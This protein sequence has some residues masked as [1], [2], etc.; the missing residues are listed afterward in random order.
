MI[1]DSEFS[2]ATDFLSSG[3]VEMAGPMKHFKSISGL[4]ELIVNVENIR[5]MEEVLTCDGK[6]VWL[7]REKHLASLI[8][9]ETIKLNLA[10]L[11]QSEVPFS[12]VACKVACEA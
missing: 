10:L 2:D 9:G 11:V 6:Y 5:R 3:G 4:H 12:L 7:Q 8:V 1:D